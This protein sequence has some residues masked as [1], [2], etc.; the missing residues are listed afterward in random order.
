MKKKHAN[1]IMLQWWCLFIHLQT[2]YF[3]C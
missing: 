1:I 3:L 2:L